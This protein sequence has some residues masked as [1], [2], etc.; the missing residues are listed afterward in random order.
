MSRP[1]Q[2]FINKYGRA[3]FKLLIK[4]FLQGDN[5][6][7]IG[8]YFGVS[9]ERVRHWKNNF[10]ITEVKYTLKADVQDIINED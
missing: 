9:R 2:N 10:G 4:M 6:Q 3:Q 8:N 7:Q 5:N 1:I